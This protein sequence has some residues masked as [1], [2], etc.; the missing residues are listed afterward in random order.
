MKNYY[1]PP[2]PQKNKNAVKMSKITKISYNSIHI[3]FRQTYILLPDG[4]NCCILKDLYNAFSQK[5]L[6]SIKNGPDMQNFK[7]LMITNLY[8]VASLSSVFSKTMKGIQILSISVVAKEFA[9][10]K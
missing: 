10:L 6:N 5:F 2:F 8:T 1:P 4:H 9:D 3:N 7:M